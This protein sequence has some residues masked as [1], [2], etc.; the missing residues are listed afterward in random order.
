MFLIYILCHWQAGKVACRAQSRNL[1]SDII[2]IH[3]YVLYK[4][5][6]LSAQSSKKLH[7]KKTIFTSLSMAWQPFPNQNYLWNL[8]NATTF[9]SCANGYN[10]WITD[11]LIC[12]ICVAEAKQIFSYFLTHNASSKTLL[13]SA[14]IREFDVKV[15]CMPLGYP[16][17]LMLKNSPLVRISLIP[18]LLL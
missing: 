4:W 18:D 15:S 3:F 11:P 17:I 14:N 13:Y 5:V 6:I 8:G 7:D 16:W 10:S 1:H 9:N 12:F 2:W